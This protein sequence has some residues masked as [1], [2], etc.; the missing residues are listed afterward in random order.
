[1]TIV[2][3]IYVTIS[4]TAL[5]LTG[6]VGYV[7]MNP[8]KAERVAS[9]L[10]KLLRF[11]S[12]K[13]ERLYVKYSTQSTVNSFLSKLHKSVPGIA[14]DKVSLEWINENITE[15]EFLESGELV[16]RMKQSRN[17]NRNLINATVTFV[18][19]SLLQKAKHYIAK[20]QK[21]ALNLFATSKI[22][23]EE[24][25]HTMGEFVSCYLSEAM[26]N[27]KINSLYEKFEEIHKIN[28]F[29]PVLITELNFLGEKV[30]GKAKKASDIYEEVNQMIN[31]LYRYSQRK[32]SE[33]TISDYAGTHCKFA[34][35]IVGK[36]YKVHTEGK[37][38]Y[39]NDI[40]NISPNVETIYLISDQGLKPFVNEIKKEL[41]GQIDFYLY[42]T[43]QYSA[44][45]KDADGN[46]MSVNNYL[47]VL[48]SRNVKTFHKQ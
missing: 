15:T 4:V 47:V 36:K 23:E 6:F 31:F 27:D 48:R 9:W 45:I 44:T 19:Y 13:A 7:L 28:I 8:E 33:D 25:P 1:M 21:E 46:D 29:F 42:N 40:K 41:E 11:A 10:Y 5:S 37:R 39:I 3:P 22:L 2:F 26:D 30:F 34:I 35:R 18:S 38:I 16:I 14:V 20:Y 32:L 12:S 17:D 24:C 43:R